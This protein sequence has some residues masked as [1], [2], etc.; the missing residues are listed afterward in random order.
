M[1]CNREPWREYAHMICVPTQNVV[2]LCEQVTQYVRADV[3]GADSPYRYLL[4]L[5]VA[6]LQLDAAARPTA[7]RAV[8][9]IR[10]RSMQPPSPELSGDFTATRS[11]TTEESSS[12][13]GGKQRKRGD[14]DGTATSGGMQSQASESFMADLDDTNYQVAAQQP[15]PQQPQPQQ[16]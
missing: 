1:I 4:D 8:A 3:A 16:Q 11:N 2:P 15:Q 5:C 9:C 10:A 14:G 12:A 6:G 13:A 7:K